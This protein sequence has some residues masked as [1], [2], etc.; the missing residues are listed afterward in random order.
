MPRAT[1]KREL[2][3]EHPPGS[4]GRLSE[5]WANLKVTSTPAAGSQVAQ[6]LWPYPLAGV[7]LSERK[8]ENSPTV[9]CS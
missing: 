7:A 1:G 3:T 4:G 6:N 9:K 8:Q 5:G 2:Q